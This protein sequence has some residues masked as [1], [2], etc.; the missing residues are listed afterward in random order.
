MS[1]VKHLFVRTD[2]PPCDLEKN[3]V[4]YSELSQTYS[5]PFS[6]SPVG[7]ATQRPSVRTPPL[8]PLSQHR[9]HPSPPRFQRP[10][11][12]PPSPA[13]PM[14]RLPEFSRFPQFSPT[15]QQTYSSPDRLKMYTSLPYCHSYTISRRERDG[16]HHPVTTIHTK[17]QSGLSSASPAVSGAGMP[18]DLTPI[19]NKHDPLLPLAIECIQSL[20]ADADRPR[21]ALTPSPIP[22]HAAASRTPSAQFLQ[23][24][25]V[26]ITD[27]TRDSTATAKTFY[28]FQEFGWLLEYI[29]AEGTERER[30]P[31][32]TRESK[33]SF[34]ESCAREKV[35]M[36]V[37]S[38]RA[39]LLAQGAADGGVGGEKGKIIDKLEELQAFFSEDGSR[40]G[41]DGKATV[42]EEDTT[43]R[44]GESGKFDTSLDRSLNFSRPLRVDIPASTRSSQ[45]S[46]FPSRAPKDGYTD[47]V[48]PR[49]TQDFNTGGL[50]LSDVVK[51]KR[52]SF[53]HVEHPLEDHDE[54]E[55]AVN[56]SFA[57]DTSEI[58]AT[59][60]TERQRRTRPP[61]PINSI[62]L[63]R[64]PSQVDPKYLSRP[65]DWTPVKMQVAPA[66]FAPQEKDVERAGESWLKGAKV[67]TREEEMA[68]WMFVL[69]FI[70]PVFWII[71]GWWV[72]PSSDKVERRQRPKSNTR[73]QARSTPHT[74]VDFETGTPF[75]P[76]TP[77]RSSYPF[78]E[79]VSSPT[80]LLGQQSTDLRGNMVGQK[81]Q[82]SETGMGKKE[83]WWTHEE[84]MV[85]YCRHAAIVAIP[86]MVFAAVMLV[87]SFV[88]IK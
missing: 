47:I 62:R 41:S 40:E 42:E 46:I 63:S 88:F 37:R 75:I 58:A 65:A 61:V 68:R 4:P 55:G 81:T 86:G 16:S 18:P 67:K 28:A 71:G 29:G 10:R 1:F 45:T 24:P 73:S 33:A 22:T 82:L 59:L 23:V 74:S 32:M 80:A 34:V 13:S 72:Y 78:H 76:I 66:P 79:S 14:T 53:E 57:S 9:E 25:Q 54:S 60:G 26:T 21:N 39:T 48:A 87:V 84:P 15:K 3:A 11:A 2:D 27:N 77:N 44:G 64:W 7:T 43:L 5:D 20:C 12:Q 50:D 31:A 83:S 51:V 30:F 19:S 52:F 69:G 70:C 6:K 36:A 56:D 85:R 17:P 38:A 35:N 49:L 8:P